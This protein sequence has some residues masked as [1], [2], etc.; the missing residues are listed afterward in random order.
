[1]RT[2]SRESFVGKRPG[3]IE[4]NHFEHAICHITLIS[5][6]PKVT[7]KTASRRSNLKLAALIFVKNEKSARAVLTKFFR[8]PEVMGIHDHMLCFSGFRG[9]DRTLFWLG[10][11]G[12]L[13]G[14]VGGVGRVG[15]G[16]AGWAG[17]V[18]WVGE[19]EGGGLGRGWVGRRGGGWLRR[20]S[21]RGNRGAQPPANFL[22]IIGW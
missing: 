12:G 22:F 17:G 16:G 2:G 9:V 15:A 13:G 20:C 18:G 11:L 4:N 5:Q 19:V 6:E 14:V 3:N 7:L 21:S 8:P 1:M 10:G